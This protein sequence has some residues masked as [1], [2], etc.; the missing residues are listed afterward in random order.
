MHAWY[1]THKPCSIAAIPY[2]NVL[3]PYRT[4]YCT[5][6]NFQK[7]GMT[8]YND[9]VYDIQLAEVIEYKSYLYIY[10]EIKICF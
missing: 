8:Y 3:K 4:L 7:N 6:N 9:K 2:V 1:Q 10:L 5:Q